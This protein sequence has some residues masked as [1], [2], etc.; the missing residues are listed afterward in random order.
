[1]TDAEQKQNPTP[2]RERLMRLRSIFMPYAMKRASKYYK[3]TGFYARFVHY[4]SAEAALQI[5]K[6]K[7]IWMRNT[8][9]MSD[10]SEVMHGYDILWKF[11]SNENNKGEFIKA[12][13]GVASG[14][15]E[16]AIKLFDQ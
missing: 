2:E 5:I 15:A 6:S 3:A 13:E 10:Y 14:V 16:E 7:R 4:T 8:T 12:L 9:C 11:F 1:M